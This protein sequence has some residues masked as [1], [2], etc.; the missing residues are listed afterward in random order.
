MQFIVQYEEKERKIAHLYHILLFLLDGKWRLNGK[1]IDSHAFHS[2][3]LLLYEEY[4]IHKNSMR[5][6]GLHY[7]C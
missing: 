3:S 5:T 7:Q 1:R 2:K 6:S 4:R